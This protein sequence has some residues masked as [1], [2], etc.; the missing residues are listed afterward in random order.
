MGS[1]WDKGWDK[2]KGKWKDGW[3]KGKRRRRRD[4]DD[5]DEEDDEPPRK[6]KKAAP[7]AED[8]PRRDSAA[9][10][11]KSVPEWIKAQATLFGHLPRLP[12][13]WIR[14]R[15]KS[16]GTIYFYNTKTGVSAFD[17]PTA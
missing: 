16:Q 4:D 1:G 9:E 5:S 17:F 3:S 13:N 10:D 6:K 8:P 15:S 14:I 2:G 12:Q 11:P 7:L